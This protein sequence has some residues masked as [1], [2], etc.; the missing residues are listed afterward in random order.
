MTPSRI[1]ARRF[2]QTLPRPLAL[3]LLCAACSKPTPTA[4]DASTGA[5]ASADASTCSQTRLGYT[6]P[7]TK[8]TLAPPRPV[9]PYYQWQSNNGYCGEVS[10]LQAGMNNGLWASQYNVRLL[11][12]YQSQGDDGYAAG[13]PLLQ[14]GPEGYC[15]AH[16][17]D[18]GV[19]TPHH[20]AQLLLDA[21]DVS[22][23]E[24]SVLACANNAGLAA[25]VYAAPANL[26]GQPALEDFVAW[27]K[28]ELRAGHWVTTGVLTQGGTNDEYDH[29]VS[30]VSVGTNHAGDD[31][32]FYADDVLYLEDHGAYT[33][34]GDAETNN[35]AIPPGAN[36]DGNGCV[37]YV[38]GIRA[39]DLGQ[40]RASFDARTTGQPYALALPNNSVDGLR[41]YGLSVKG[42]LDDDG[43]TLPVVVTIAKTNI[44]GVD[45]PK[46]P[47]AGYHYEAPYVGSSDDGSSCTNSPPSPWMDLELRAEVQGLSAGKSY[48]LYRYLFDGVK[49]AGNA[50][51]VGTNVALPVPRASF[52]ANKALASSARTFVA[53]GPTH[54]E[55]VALRSDH[56]IVFRA[57]PADAP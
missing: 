49:A 28:K 9:R 3:L 41:N 10:L 13:T 45:N 32:A 54:T 43:V 46:A 20:D 15:A 17:G 35:P 44:A 29:I 2:R 12:G 6:P 27:I 1:A 25:S 48:T 42:P 11:C 16:T 37:P 22:K 24:N 23:G 55:T 21:R 19:A 30:I 50:K 31:T 34:L 36:G 40:T 8:H 18:D 14:S 7:A 39:G 4:N 51:P 52:N 47:L 33:F 53:D 38:Y 5:G 57:V 56:V 26:D